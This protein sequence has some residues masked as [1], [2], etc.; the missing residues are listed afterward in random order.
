MGMDLSDLERLF[1]QARKLTGHTEYVVVGS[2]SI[3]GAVRPKDVPARMLASIDVDCYTRTDPARIFEV[4]DALGEGSAFEA[5]HGYYL[6][7][8]SPHVPT[9][10]EH[11]DRRL[12]RISM[13]HG[14]VAYFLDPDDAAVSKYARCEPRD[15][16]WIR[17]GLL[18]GLLSIANIE[19]GLRDTVF[20][21]AE[22]RDRAT[23]AFAEDRRV[24]KVR[25]RPDRS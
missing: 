5:R 3:L 23:R 16:E 18:A 21:D 4:S 7:P 17:A 15:R 20:L 2:L 8:V 10:P 22:E 6:D 9:L 24:A 13:K 1:D 19:R 25:P 12:L 11:W 14:I